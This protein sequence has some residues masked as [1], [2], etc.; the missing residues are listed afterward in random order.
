MHINKIDNIYY[1][2]IME[3]LQVDYEISIVAYDVTIW[4][5]IIEKEN[6]TTS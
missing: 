4:Y 1:S 3:N 2:H 5:N 6:S